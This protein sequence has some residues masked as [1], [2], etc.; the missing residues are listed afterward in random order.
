MTKN[1]KEVIS[2]SDLYDVDGTNK[3]SDVISQMINGWVDV[4]KDVNE[5]W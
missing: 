3:I 1:D 2:M 4:E 5:I